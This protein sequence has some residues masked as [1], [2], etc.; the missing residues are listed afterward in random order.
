MSTSNIQPSPFQRS[1]SFH[2]SFVRPENEVKERTETTEENKIVVDNAII[3]TSNDDQIDNKDTDTDNTN[4]SKSTEE[5][6]DHNRTMV[7]QVDRTDLRLISPDR[8]II[9]LH[10]HHKDITTC[11]QVSYNP[12]LLKFIKAIIVFFS[13]VVPARSILVS[14]VKMLRL[15]KHI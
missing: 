1:Q 13:R 8:K 9:L 5:I 4:E 12:K 3:K 2:T 6:G 7:L 14:F 15:H 10:K 11:I